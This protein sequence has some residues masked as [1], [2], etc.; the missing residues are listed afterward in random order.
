MKS[1][2]KT[3]EWVNEEINKDTG[4]LTTNKKSVSVKVNVDTFY[5]TY[6]ESISWLIGITNAKELQVLS[7]I[8]LHAEYNKGICLLPSN[9]RKEF[10]D[11]LEMN[12]NTFGV[13]LSRLAKRGL[14]RN[15]GGK[16][17]I[18]PICFWKG[19]SEERNKL[20]QNEGL[21]LTYKFKATK[22]K[23]NDIK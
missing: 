20:L 13:C 6:I 16:V 2:N 23:E 8:C 4:E 12:S 22:E 1:Y 3:I 15:D 21:E 19:S 7:I 17:E 18:N 10:C 9:R 5:F 14:I 11:K